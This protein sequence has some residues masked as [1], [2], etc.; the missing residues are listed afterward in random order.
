MTTTRRKITSKALRA[1]C[2]DISE[3]TQYRWAHDPAM[4]FPKPTYINGRKFYDEAEVDGW[5]ESRSTVA[6]KVEHL[7]EGRHRAKGAA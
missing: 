4:D 6:P 7:R 5:L 2:G 3:M 1:K